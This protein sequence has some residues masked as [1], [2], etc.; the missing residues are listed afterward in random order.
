[1]RE[2]GYSDSEPTWANSYLWPEL[3]RLIAGRPWKDKRAFDLGCGNGATANMLSALGFETTAVDT[4]ETGIALAHEAFP[5]INAFV[6]SAYDDLASRYGTFPLVVSLEVVEHCIDPRA[7]AKTFFAL[8]APGGLGVLSTPH[9]GYW[10]NLAL[11]VSGK[12]DAHFTALWDG[13]HVKFWS[14]KTLRVL[15][16]EAGAINVQFVRVGRLPPLAKSMIAIVEKN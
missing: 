16:E 11:A 3:Q 14:I 4:S 2:Y 5:H 12:M 10:K 13:G 15:L 7:F 1:M 8:I 6:G 9:H